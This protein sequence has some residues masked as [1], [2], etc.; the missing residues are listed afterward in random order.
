MD[1]SCQTGVELQPAEVYTTTD[2]DNE[3]DH[4]N[5]GRSTASIPFER[6]V[7]SDIERRSATR[8]RLR[9]VGPGNATTAHLPS[10]VA[11][12]D[13]IDYE[14]IEAAWAIIDATNRRR[15]MRGLSPIQRGPRKQM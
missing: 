13:A 8:R 2:P 15:A 12:Q 6:P 7:T 1:S 5:D 4:D 14:V 3:D 9:E 10:T 11:E